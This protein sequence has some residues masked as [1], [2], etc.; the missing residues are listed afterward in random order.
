M[1]YQGQMSC[2]SGCN[3]GLMV[4]ALNYTSVEGL[5]TET[6][7][8]YKGSA[9]TCRYDASKATY[10]TTSFVAIEKKEEAMVAALN[11]LGPLSVGVDA[12]LWS[13]YG[14]GIYGHIM[15]CGSKLNHGVAIVGYGTHNKEDYWII[16]NSWGTGWGEKGYMR[17]IR[18][19][20]KCGVD[21]YVNSATI[22][23]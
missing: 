16:R 5:M 21:N 3:G 1:I 14:G 8:P 6:D 22:T 23:A 15:P 9:G 7:Y 10:R 2:D 13:F 19:K 12:S 4:N 17:L 11:E 18:G 20:N